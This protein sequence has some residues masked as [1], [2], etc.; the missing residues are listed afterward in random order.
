L[1]GGKD[2]RKLTLES[3]KDIPGATGGGHKNATGAKMSVSDLPVFKENVENFAKS[4]EL[5][6][7][8]EPKN[9]K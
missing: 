7:S 1:R 4:K 3:I 8:L 6:S 9:A 2:I 5:K